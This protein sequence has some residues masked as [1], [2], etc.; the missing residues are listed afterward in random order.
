MPSAFSFSRRQELGL[1]DLFFGMLRRFRKKNAVAQA[2]SPAEPQVPTIDLE[3]YDHALFPLRFRRLHEHISAVA[4]LAKHGTR[5]CDRRAGYRVVMLVS[6]N[7]GERFCTGVDIE[8][9]SCN[10]GRL[11]AKTVASMSTRSMTIKECYLVDPRGRWVAKS[12]DS[13]VI[14]AGDSVTFR[15]VLVSI[16][17]E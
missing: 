17:K 9:V 10:D 6:D 11:V 2:A 7:E 1:P 16:D 14:C 4:E 5:L 3:L 12:S 8:S 13:V 15:F